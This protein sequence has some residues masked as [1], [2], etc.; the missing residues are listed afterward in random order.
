MRR[1]EPHRQTCDGNA[2]GDLNL[3]HDC[4][5]DLCQ[6]RHLATK[7]GHGAHDAPSHA[8]G[9]A[10]CNQS[11]ICCCFAKRV[12]EQDDGTSIIKAGSRKIVGESAPTSGLRREL[13]NGM[14]IS[15]RHTHQATRGVPMDERP[16]R[17]WYIYCILQM[18]PAN[19]STTILSYLRT[20]A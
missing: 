4:Q 13:T 2:C 8:V 18:H 16:P 12:L 11:H 19:A 10:C 5:A 6:E 1:L 7:I 20:L 17:G 3:G 14:T 15:S 9:Y